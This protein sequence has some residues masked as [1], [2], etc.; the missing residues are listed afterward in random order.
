MA[1]DANAGFREIEHTADWELEVWAPDMP[2]LLEQAARGMY[3]LS[4]VQLK[5]ESRVSRSFNL[6]MFD[7]ESLLVD[8]L[9]ELLWIL[10]GESLAFDHFQLQ[11]EE[12]NLK[13]VLQGAPVASLKKE[14]KAVTFHNLQ[15]N[16]RKNGLIVRIVFDV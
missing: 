9:N 14:I 12:G 13:T 5:S 6:E 8:F 3:A 4:G 16:R 7:E 1:N 2:A 11:I 15:I 10:E